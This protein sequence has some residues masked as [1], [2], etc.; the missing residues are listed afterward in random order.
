MLFLRLNEVPLEKLTVFRV[1]PLSSA[2]LVLVLLVSIPALATRTTQ[3]PLLWYV[4]TILAILLLFGVNDLRKALKPTAW[5]AALG[6]GKLY[7]KWR[8]YQNAH[9]G[10]DDVQVVAIPLHEIRQVSR[11]TG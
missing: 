1:F 7:L 2:I 8:S 3:K 5:L 6:N 4:L 9:W 11:I 10:M